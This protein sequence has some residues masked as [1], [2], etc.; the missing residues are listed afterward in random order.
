MDMLSYFLGRLA[1]GSGGAGGEIQIIIPETTIE[2][3]SAEGTPL[4]DGWV[5]CSAPI[6]LAEMPSLVD[7]QT[8]KITIDNTTYDMKVTYHEATGTYLGGNTSLLMDGT[9]NGEDYIFQLGEFQGS[10]TLMLFL[11]GEAG[12]HTIKLEFNQ[13]EIGS[14]E[15]LIDESGVLDSTE[16]TATEK[17]EQ[18]I[19]KAKSGSSPVVDENGIVA[20]GGNTAIDENGIVSL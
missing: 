8:Y 13:N 9:D 17:V 20:F 16:G 1:G 11:K 2:L 18:L 6:M 19:E 10:P 4:P 12:T 5:M 3:V 15:N 14:I 7:G